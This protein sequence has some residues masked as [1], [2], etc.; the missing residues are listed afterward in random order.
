MN[1]KEIA[2]IQTGGKQYVVS[3]GE[4]ITIEKLNVAP[5]EVF[6]FENVLLF[7]DEKGEFLIGNP[8]LKEFKVSGEVIEEGLGDKKRVFKY[9]P[10]KRYK[11][12]KGHR[13]PYTEVKITQIKR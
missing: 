1:K 11:I 9:K 5:G 2:V 13:Q 4:K 3:P 10:K 6:D 7:E 12:K 8:Y